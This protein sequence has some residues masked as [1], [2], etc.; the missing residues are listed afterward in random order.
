MVNTTKLYSRQTE[1]QVMAAFLFEPYIYHYV[2]DMLSRELFSDYD[3]QKVY[4]IIQQLLKD[5]KE[6]DVMEI[7][8]RLRMARS[9]RK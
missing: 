4:D 8:P 3:C 6:I 9:C 7:E 2:Q 1:V 5:G